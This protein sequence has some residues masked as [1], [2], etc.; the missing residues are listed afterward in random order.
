MSQKT[1][2]EQ[3]LK[4]LYKQFSHCSDFPLETTGATRVVFGEGNPDA[5][6]MIIG[7]APGKQE[8]ELGKPF[9][10]RSGKLLTSILEQAGLTRY[11]IFITNVVKCRPPNNRKPKPHEVALYKKLILLQEIAII[12]PRVI[13]TLGATA[14]EALLENGTKISKARG[15]VQHQNGLLIVP[16]YHPAYILRNPTKL[17]DFA[18][19]IKFSKSLL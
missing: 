4:K 11:E 7:E 13:V 6:L 3:L 10:G 19:D 9:V 1:S 2:K 5:K 14:L 18:Q 15:I 12:N 16:T 8:D 17:N